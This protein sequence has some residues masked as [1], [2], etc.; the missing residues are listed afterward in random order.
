MKK[1]LLIV[2]ILL[3]SFSLF[4]FDSFVLFGL[5][6][7]EI[8]GKSDIPIEFYINVWK[9]FG[10][11]EIYGNYCNTIYKDSLFYYM[12]IEDN[13]SLGINY[14]FE[15]FS[16]RVEHNREHDLIGKGKDKSNYTKIEIRIG[17]E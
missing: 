13:F 8:E 7:T 17:K 12:P 3:I 1:I 9:D 14:E 15:D 6:Q 2:T 10:S 16:I 4:A 11:L 5:K